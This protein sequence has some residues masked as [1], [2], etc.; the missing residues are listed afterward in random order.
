[1]SDAAVTIVMAGVVQVGLG[2]IA[3]FS[4]RAKLKYATQETKE[5]SR[6]AMAAVRKADKKLK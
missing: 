5:V 3:Y 1:M 4:L 2:I 6:D